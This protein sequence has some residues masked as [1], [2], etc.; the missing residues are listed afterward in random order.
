LGAQTHLLAFMDCFHV[1]GVVTL[2]AA[3]L[4]WL[5][6]HF[7]VGGKVPEGH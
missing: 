1:I 6:N 7:K 5:T 4:V 2:I 3:P